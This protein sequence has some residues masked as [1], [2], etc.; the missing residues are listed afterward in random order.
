M[1]RKNKQKKLVFA[2]PCRNSGKRLFG[3]PVQFI[4]PGRK[5]INSGEQVFIQIK[6]ESSVDLIPFFWHFGRGT[7]V[8][9]DD[10][11]YEL[12]GE[13]LNNN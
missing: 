5:I 9:I 4:D 1:I 8:G 12:L 2:L 10:K 11:W 6:N 7:I 13:Y 3:K